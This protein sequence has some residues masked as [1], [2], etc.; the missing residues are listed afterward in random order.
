V[1]GAVGAGAY[2]L[3]MLVI[4]LIAADSFD[5]PLTRT[6]A[7]GL[8]QFAQ[9]LL[10][11]CAALFMGALGARWARDMATVEGAASPEKRVGQYTAMGIV[12]ATTVLAVAVLLSG[13]GVLM[14]LAALAVLGFLLWLV[15]GYLPDVTAGLQLRAHKVVEVTFDGAPWQLLEMGLLTTQL[16]RAGEFCRMQNRAVLEACLHGASNGTAAR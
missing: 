15:R 13:A 1:A 8:W 12:A 11:A 6:A 4:L 16:G 14:G 3:V 5:W 10:I 2:V 7:L 9:H